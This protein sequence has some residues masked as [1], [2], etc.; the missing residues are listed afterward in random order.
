M[1]S[2]ERCCMLLPAELRKDFKQHSDAEEVRLRCGRPMSLINAGE[3]KIISN[4]I[5][6]E[7][8]ILQVLECATGASI[9]S[10]VSSLKNGYINCKGLRLGVCGQVIYSDGQIMGFSKYSSI[11]I[12]IPHEIYGTLT[13][14]IFDELIVNPGNLLIVGPPGAG[15][16][17]ALRELVR[18]CSEAGK[19]I[20]LVDERGELAGDG[21]SFWLGPCTDVMSGISK[22]Q[23][24]IM[25]L[26]GMNPQI[27]AM[28]EITSSQDIEAIF[29]IIGCGVTVFA[30]CHGRGKD[31]MMQR[32]LYK[33]LFDKGIFTYMITIGIVNCKREYKL[34]RIHQ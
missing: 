23:A 3:E 24:S 14:N 25:L 18:L 28:D 5:I 11:A 20:S 9:H 21:D 33:T 26:R 34:E 6:N 29:E 13:A 7:K 1:N 19:R 15:K 12:R 16:T 31:D 30:T 10:S 32:S 27:I 8:D 17:T 22:S 4:K 2:F